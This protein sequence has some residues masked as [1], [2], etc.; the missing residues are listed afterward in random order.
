ML[1][2]SDVEIH[3]DFD[4]SDDSGTS[5]DG[6]DEGMYS[7]MSGEEDDPFYSVEQGPLVVNVAC[8]Q[9]ER[10]L[11]DRGCAVRLCADVSVKMFSTDLVVRT[12]GSAI[13]T[14]LC[15]LGDAVRCGAHPQT[16]CAHEVGP[17]RRA[18]SCRCRV[19]NLACARCKSVVG[20]HVVKPCAL[21]LASDNNGHYWILQGDAVRGSY[22]LAQWSADAYHRSSRGHPVVLGVLLRSD[23]GRKRTEV[24]WLGVSFPQAKATTT[25][26]WCFPKIVSHTPH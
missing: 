18:E 8:A 24:H 13:G 25:G 16:R 17:G 3:A 7:D 11:C 19:V 22:V 2:S 26:L 4:D 1:R 20:Y 15:P 10:L 5:L 14:V 21:C 23:C 12:R 9:C 6:D